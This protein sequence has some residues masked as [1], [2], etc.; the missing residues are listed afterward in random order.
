M[1]S[2]NTRSAQEVLDDHLYQRKTGTVEGDLD[3]NFAEDVVVMSGDGIFH[4]HDGVRSTA[5]ILHDA[6]HGASFEYHTTLVEGELAFLQW[7]ARSDDATVNDGAD[8][9]IIRDGKIVGQTI[10]F[11]PVRNLQKDEQTNE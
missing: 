10:H 11:T 3:R 5:S 1:T 8:S 6:L 2:E 7:S 9:F 4:G